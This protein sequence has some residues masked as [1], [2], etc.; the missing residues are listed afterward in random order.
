MH[1]G[2]RRAS[3][4]RT[5]SL[6]VAS[7]GALW[8]SRVV[9]AVRRPRRDGARVS[10]PRRPPPTA[11][12][13]GCSPRSLRA[14]IGS[15]AAGASPPPPI[16]P[17]STRRARMPAP[18]GFVRELVTTPGHRREL[19]VARRREF[20]AACGLVGLGA[21]EQA[22]T[23]WRGAARNSIIVFFTLE[24]VRHPQPRFRPAAL[25]PD[26]PGIEGALLDVVLRGQDE[27]L[28][29]VDRHGRRPA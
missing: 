23:C 13:C 11:R 9:H 5:Q 15:C 29:Y 21:G 17:R 14:W 22:G 2:S 25:C 24:R 4:W 3:S 10:S 26:V 8:R 27:P 28:R 7:R 1:R 12:W 19:A 20:P 18:G 6:R 16:P